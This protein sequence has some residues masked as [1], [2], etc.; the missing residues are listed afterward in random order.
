M[1]CFGIIQKDKV[2]IDNARGLSAMLVLRF[3]FSNV[4]SH[5]GG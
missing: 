4:E 2:T 1:N 5:L 3:T